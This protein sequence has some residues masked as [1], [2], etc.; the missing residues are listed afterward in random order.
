MRGLAGSG[1][2]APG[3]AY[4]LSFLKQPHPS[5]AQLA[6]LGKQGSCFGH[7]DSPVPPAPRRSVPPSLPAS[8]SVLVQARMLE[9]SRP[10]NAH[11]QIDKW[12]P[13]LSIS[14]LNGSFKYC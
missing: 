2:A 8:P 5:K 3:I 12:K 7:L 13:L 1:S 11:S 6:A 14:K 4:A 10:G 9:P